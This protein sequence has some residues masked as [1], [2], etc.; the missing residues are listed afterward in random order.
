M[1]TRQK[2]LNYL[3]YSN[4]NLLGII[5]S[6]LMPGFIVFYL[7]LQEIHKVAIIFG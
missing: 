2:H 7:F 1:A 4:L 6:G 5:I 3:N